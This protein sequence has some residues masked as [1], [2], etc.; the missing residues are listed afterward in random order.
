MALGHNLVD[1]W[2]LSLHWGFVSHIGGY[3]MGHVGVLC[4]VVCITNLWCVL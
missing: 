1:L 3:A 2:F 4:M